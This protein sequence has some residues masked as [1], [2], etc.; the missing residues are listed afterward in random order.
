MTRTNHAPQGPQQTSFADPDRPELFYHL[1]HPP[2][3]ISRS[4][5][6]FAVSFL[7]N[8]PAEVESCAVIGWLPAESEA[9]T[10]ESE[11]AGLNDFRPNGASLGLK[12]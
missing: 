7:E 5:A 10:G 2:T 9:A 11:E 1:Y 3:S 4:S 8:A 6:V 12:L